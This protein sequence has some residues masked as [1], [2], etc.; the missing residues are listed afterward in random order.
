MNSLFGSIISINKKN[1]SYKILSKGHRN[2]QG[3]YFDEVNKFILSTEHGPDG[4]DELNIINPRF[5]NIQNFGW[6]ISSYGEHYP[7]KHHD[8]E[9][10]NRIDLMEKL[11][12][13]K[14][15]H[16]D[17][18]FIEP[19]KFWTPSIAISEVIKVPAKFNPSF[20]NDFFISSMG[21]V[22]AEGDHS[23]HHLRFNKEFKKIIF[24]D[25]II[26]KE[27]IRDII[28]SKRDN[29]VILVLGNTPSLAVLT[30]KPN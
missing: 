8:W 20:E 2:Q 14:K 7:S 1:K 11:A 9:N 24:E 26:I 29:S 13:L 23:I 17:Y 27:R 12:P 25:K 21:N 28:Y 3:L 22:V 18:G 16:S 10:I 19:I 15:S 6:P 5:K 4:G 30:Y